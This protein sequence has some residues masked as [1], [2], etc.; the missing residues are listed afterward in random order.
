MSTLTDDPTC[1]QCGERRSKVRA[2]SL[3]CCTVSG[4]E[5]V[6]VDQEWERHRWA[7][8][9]DRELT[10]SGIKPEAFEKYRRASV[11]TL[12]YA[13]C[14]DTRRGHMPA[15]EETSAGWGIEVGRCIRCGAMTPPAKSP[16]TTEG[17]RA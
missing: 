6:E 14:V 17:D 8:W 9:T 3:F 16:A 2:E 1:L 10:R 4:Y 7:D 11:G 13:D 5:Y 12:D 15:D